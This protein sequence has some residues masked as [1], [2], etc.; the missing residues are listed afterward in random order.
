MVLPALLSM[1][2]SECAAR[3][4][5]WQSSC[6]QQHL[7]PGPAAAVSAAAPVQAAPAAAGL[8]DWLHPAV[9]LVLKMHLLPAL[10]CLRPACC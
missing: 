8:P 1:C 4:T 2:C 5:V 10:H 3:G 9:L 7:S 6:H